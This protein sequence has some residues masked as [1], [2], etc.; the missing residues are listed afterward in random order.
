MTKFFKFSDK[1]KTYSRCIFACFLASL[2]IAASLCF[3]AHSFEINEI[4]FSPSQ[5]YELTGSEGKQPEISSKIS[6]EISDLFGKK[7]N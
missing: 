5:I 7:E 3:L 4:S 1:I 6:E 2:I